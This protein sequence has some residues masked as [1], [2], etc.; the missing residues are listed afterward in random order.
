MIEVVIRNLLSNALKY[1]HENGVVVI[2]TRS[3]AHGMIIEIVDT[4]IGMDPEKASNLFR[5][6]YSA[7]TVGTKGEKG[8]G[9]GLLLCKEFVEKHNGKI[10]VKSELGKGSTFTVELP[11]KN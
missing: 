7:S 1:S 9:L 10:H 8:S 11:H 5:L 2:N 3:G 4:G 6:E